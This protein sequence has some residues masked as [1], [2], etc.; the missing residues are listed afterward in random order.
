MYCS[1]SVGPEYQ[2]SYQDCLS[3]CEWFFLLWPLRMQVVQTRRKKQAVVSPVLGTAEEL[4]CPRAPAISLSLLSF[5]LSSL[6]SS[7]SPLF[8]PSFPPCS[9]FF[10]SLT[11]DFQIITDP[12]VVRNSTERPCVPTTIFPQGYI[13]QNCNT[14]YQNPD[15]DI[16]EDTEHFHHPKDPSCAFVAKPTSLCP[17]ASSLATI[18]LLSISIIL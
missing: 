10:S 5:S 9:P 12:T 4:Q 11:S 14:R 1:A 17:S 6:P 7:L 8:F 15:I 16:E 18:N 2:T 13:L 3:G